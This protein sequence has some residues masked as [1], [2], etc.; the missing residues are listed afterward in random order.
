MNNMT[1]GKFDTEIDG[2][3]V[4]VVFLDLNGN[5]NALKTV[6][7][8]YDPTAQKLPIVNCYQFNMENVN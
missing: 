6:Y 1:A 7:F 5:V 8:D 4:R 3:G 2:T